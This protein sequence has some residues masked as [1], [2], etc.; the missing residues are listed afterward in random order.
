[1]RVIERT[2]FY[3][4]SRNTFEK[5][6][7]LR[8]NMTEAEK[9]VWDKLKN[10]NVFKARFRR[11]HPIGI[12]IVDFYCHECKLAI[13]IDG[14][15]HKKNEVIEYDDG[16]SHDIE[17]YGIKILRFTNNEVFTDL[18]N[19]IEKILKAIADFESRLS[20]TGGKQ[21]G[22]RY[23]QEMCIKISFKRRRNFFIQ[24]FIHPKSYS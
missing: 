16:R 8:N 11:Q 6:R 10:R 12:F 14:E 15:I 21:Q 17:K 24:F 3:G 2:M 7:L 23:I 9:I 5:A 4:A 13:E 18:N 22:M 1:M 19:I 20:G